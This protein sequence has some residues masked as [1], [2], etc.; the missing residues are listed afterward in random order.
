MERNESRLLLKPG[1]S[2]LCLAN[3]VSLA[4]QGTSLNDLFLLCSSLTKLK[5]LEALPHCLTASVI[6][7]VP[8]FY[9]PQVISLT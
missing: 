5:T 1:F 3:Y 4:W 2:Q 7:M 8:V 9:K 6:L